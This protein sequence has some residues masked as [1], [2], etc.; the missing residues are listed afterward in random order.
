MQELE[1]LREKL[2]QRMAQPTLLIICNK[3]FI[4]VRE[5]QEFMIWCLT[6][7]IYYKS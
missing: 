7:T 1:W 6:S 2:R 3:P 5:F 4:R